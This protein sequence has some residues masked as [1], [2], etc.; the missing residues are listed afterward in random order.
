MTP[1]SQ[2]ILDLVVSHADLPSPYSEEPTLTIT[3]RDLWNTVEKVVEVWWSPTGFG[4]KDDARSVGFLRIPHCVCLNEHATK[5]YKFSVLS[6]S[7][8]ER[9]IK[10]FKQ[11]ISLPQAGKTVQVA[12]MPHLIIEK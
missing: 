2:A 11:E 9:F 7:I 10:D 6:T 5:N 3:S 1:R 4:G 12:I 8:A